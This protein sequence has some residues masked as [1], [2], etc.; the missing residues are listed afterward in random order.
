VVIGRVVNEATG[1]DKESLNRSMKMTVPTMGPN[2]EFKPLKRN[3]LT[4]LS[5]KAAYLIPQLAL[6]DSG[7]CFDEAAQTYTYCC[8]MPPVT[9]SALNKPLSASRPDCATAAWDNM[10]ERLDNRSFAR[11]LSLLDNLML[12]QR[13]GQSLTE[14]VHFMRQNFDDYNKTCEMIDGSAPINPHNLGLL[15]LRGISTT[16]HFGKVKQCVINAFDTNY[17]LSAE[18]VMANILHLAQNMDDDAPD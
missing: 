3:F 12:R 8:C 4:F 16:C 11:S 7:I 9:T 1:F 2:T 18:E 10:C 5:L 17:L 14:Y 15:M 6:R 13:P